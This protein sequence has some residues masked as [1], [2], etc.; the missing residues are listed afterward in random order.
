MVLLL[1]ACWLYYQRG[2]SVTVSLRIVKCLMKLFRDFSCRYS[3][4]FIVA[5]SIL[6]ITLF[7]FFQRFLECNKL[8]VTNHLIYSL[9]FL[10]SN[11]YHKPPL[12]YC[13]GMDWNFPYLLMRHRTLPS[14]LCC[15][16]FDQAWQSI[17]VLPL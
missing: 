6:H 13:Q 17:S 5:Q 8:S 16:T 10:P 12:T 3:R 9:R 7:H 4:H 11:R 14:S 2:Y 15:G 1:S